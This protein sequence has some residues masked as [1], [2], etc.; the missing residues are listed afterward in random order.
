[1]LGQIT[2]YKAEG[3]WVKFS[4]AAPEYLAILANFVGIDRSLLYVYGPQGKLVYHEILPAECKAIAGLP[5]KKE[6]GK[7]AQALLIGCGQNVWRYDPVR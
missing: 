7:P 3:T 4:D 6:D 2:T 5:M 1:L